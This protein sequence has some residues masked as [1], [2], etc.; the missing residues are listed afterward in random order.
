MERFT[1][2]QLIQF[3]QY[4]LSQDRKK[5]FKAA[6]RSRKNALSF[7]QRLALIHDADIANFK[8][9]IEENPEIEFTPSKEV[10]LR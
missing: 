2:N 8:L 7:R 6:P 3:G 9:A 1:E 4:L 5:S 10:I